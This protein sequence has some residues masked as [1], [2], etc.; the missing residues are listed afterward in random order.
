MLGNAKQTTGCFILGAL[1]FVMMGC[2]SSSSSSSDTTDDT[3][4][5]VYAVV[6]TVNG[7]TFS[8]ETTTPN[9]TEQLEMKIELPDDAS[10]ELQFSSER[11]TGDGSITYYE[12]DEF[13]SGTTTVWGGLDLDWDDISEPYEFE[14]G[15]SETGNIFDVELSVRNAVLEV[16]ATESFR[17]E[18]Q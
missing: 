9:A 5:T 14:L 17:F 13:G 12:E 8:V 10:Y 1:I 3:T 15:F 11:V 4:E 18:V 7:V 6:E 2:T 16:I